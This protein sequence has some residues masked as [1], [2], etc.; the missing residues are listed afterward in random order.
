MTTSIAKAIDNGT[1]VASSILESL[2]YLTNAG[3]TGSTG[4]G[5]SSGG[6]GGSTGG[7]SYME[8]ASIGV[9]IALTN[10]LHQSM[11]DIDDTS[12]THSSN[13]HSHSKNNNTST[14]TEIQYYLYALPIAC[15]LTYITPRRWDNLAYT[16]QM[17]AFHGNEHCIAPALWKLLQS[18]SYLYMNET[19]VLN[20]KTGVTGGGTG[21]GGVDD[22][23]NDM[24]ELSIDQQQSTSTNTN[25]NTN[26]PHNF[27]QQTI[28]KSSKLYMKLSV[29]IQLDLRCFKET[30][31]DYKYMS[32]KP[33]CS[34]LEYYIQ[35]GRPI[36]L[37]SL[38]EQ[39]LPYSILHSNYNDISMGKLKANDKL[40][41]SLVLDGTGGSGG[42]YSRDDALAML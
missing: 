24:Q 22:L 25:I 40:T 16:Y 7:L 4:S 18:M 26:I 20:N 42:L 21:A 23:N 9:D 28:I 31:A 17:E 6:S 2:Q 32:M 39:Y 12:H 30:H 14:V 3:S 15:A 19:V 5:S 8:Q 35:L 1:G 27:Y 33:M 37:Y 36:L 29:N 10:E 41:C 34:I 13:S 11:V 38:L